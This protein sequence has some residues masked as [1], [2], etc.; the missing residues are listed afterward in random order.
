[1]NNEMIQASYVAGFRDRLA[2]VLEKESAYTPFDHLLRQKPL[3]E[4]VAAFLRKYLG[5]I[6]D[7]GDTAAL[8]K[9]Q[10]EFLSGKPSKAIQPEL[11]GFDDLLNKQ[12]AEKVAGLASLLARMKQPLIPRG[13]VPR[14]GDRTVYKIL[15]TIDPRLGKKYQRKVEFRPSKPFSD[16]DSITGKSVDLPVVD[17]MLD[18]TEGMDDLGY[19]SLRLPA[20]PS[21]NSVIDKLTNY[22]RKQTKNIQGYV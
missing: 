7:G 16:S 9:I 13:T 18:V 15:N 1:M 10:Q 12:S 19:G 11:P 3:P 4:P 20:K 6:D 22:A 21:Q 17:R 2:S 5:H 14:T 8:S